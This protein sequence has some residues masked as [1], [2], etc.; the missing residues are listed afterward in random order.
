LNRAPKKFI[1]ASSSYFSVYMK[2]EK[3]TNMSSEN[4]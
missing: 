1:P 2:L 3:N 4:P